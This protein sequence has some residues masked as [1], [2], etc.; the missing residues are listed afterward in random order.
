MRKLSFA[1]L[2]PPS[3]PIAAERNATA[4][5][6]L[7]ALATTLAPLNSTMIAVALPGI[8]AD[9]RIGVGASNWLVVT[10]LIAM[11][12]VQPIA[13]SLG[14]SYGRRRII[15][16]AL[17]GFLIA[18]VAA[19]FAPSFTALV[20]FR[21]GQ[22]VAG[23]FALPNGAALVREHLP[24]ERRGSTYGLI[25]GAAGL[26][27]GLGPPLGGLLVGLGG[28]RAIFALN[29]PIALA[30][31]ALGV[32]V[33]PAAIRRA[34]VGRLDVLGVLLL[35]GWLGCFALFSS[36]LRGGGAGI[37]PSVL[38][39]GTVGLL[40]GFVFWEL[41][42][43]HPVVRLD[44][45]RVPTFSAAAAAVALSNLAMY[46]TLLMLPQFLTLVDRRSSTEIGLILAALSVPMAALSPFGGRLA[47][48]LGRRQV[49]LVGSALA[50]VAF[51]PILWL[52]T[53]WASYALMIPLAL[54][55]CGLGLQS[56]AVQAA[57]IEAAPL[58]R[59]GV[60]SGVFSTSRYLGSIVG[61]A[62]LGVL[63]GG[64]D[65]PVGP[66]LLGAAVMVVVAAL[67][68]LLATSRLGR[69][70]KSASTPGHLAASAAPDGKAIRTL[71]PSTDNPSLSEH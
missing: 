15:L 14:D 49:A 12:V 44:L 47:D 28:W 27:A 51:V 63:L 56:P 13:G 62:A 21:L 19:L 8:A 40:V 32:V 61:T 59:A 38:A 6:V 22:A 7:V 36:S 41:R 48:G 35:T 65:G 31:L 20:V 46:S 39:L 45:F 33:L 60:A 3:P 52:G 69:E 23:A 55:G 18:S 71:H 43:A 25:G 68:A 11:A 67:G 70:R 29:I 57:A 58:D 17:V 4:L 42:A 2:A 53:G 64:S 66:G 26:A 5:I 16:L 34:E 1:P 54:A 37:P 10:Y 9:F 24:E 30:T 50:L